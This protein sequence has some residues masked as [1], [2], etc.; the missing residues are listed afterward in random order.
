MKKPIVLKKQLK[1]Q[2]KKLS[3]RLRVK[4][5]TLKKIGFSSLFV[6]TTL[7]A[8]LPGQALEFPQT[9]DRGAPER[10]SGGGT[11]G[12]RCAA[13]IDN[14]IQALVPK[15]NVSTFAEPQAK[16]WLHIP[17]DLSKHTA[18]VFIKNP[19]THEIIYEQ[20]TALPKL[21]ND[22]L[23]EIQLPAT[24]ADG[25]PLLA[26][27]QDYFWEFAIICDAADRTRDRFTQGF[28]HKIT[29][30]KVLEAQLE[31]IFRNLE[32][33][34]GG[35]DAMAV[36]MYAAAKLWQETL[37]MAM[38]TISYRQHYL[39]EL[40]TSVDLAELGAYHNR[41]SVREMQQLSLPQ[42]EQ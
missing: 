25:S 14:P 16:L 23:I 10:T 31:E 33:A 30:D 11:R 2:S 1:K 24:N 5:S 29:N 26:D 15:N 36:E 3:R 34:S 17:A 41:Y 21:E 12:D 20:Q 42:A 32:S 7:L 18:E 19:T 4:E 8:T 38:R 13:D 40:L 37:S 35:P 9:S 39:S 22:G 28:L 27:N 6:L